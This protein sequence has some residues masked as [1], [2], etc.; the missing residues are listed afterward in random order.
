MYVMLMI[1]QWGAAGMLLLHAC[2][3]VCAPRCTVCF[4]DIFYICH[5]I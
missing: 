4:A 5:V 2:N 1:Q 3:F